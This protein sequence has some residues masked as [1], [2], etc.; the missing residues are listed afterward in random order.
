MHAAIFASLIPAPSS[1][2]SNFGGPRGAD[3]ERERLKDLIATIVDWD[4]VKYG[5]SPAIEKAQA[6]IR[7]AFPDRPPRL[8]DPFMGGGATGLEA[9]RLGCETHAVE[10]AEQI[11]QFM[12]QSAERGTVAELSAGASVQLVVFFVY[13]DA[14]DLFFHRSVP[15]LNW[16][17]E[18]E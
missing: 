14:G 9:L 3:E 15:R 10:W 6:L 4:Q 2:P 7:Q 12:T 17:G 8:L 5:N 16:E 13:R 1:L 18:T 11:K